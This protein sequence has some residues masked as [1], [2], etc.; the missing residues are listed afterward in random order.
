MPKETLSKWIAFR[1]EKLVGTKIKNDEGTLVC[2]VIT[3]SL[4]TQ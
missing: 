2:K 3:G 1:T 4:E